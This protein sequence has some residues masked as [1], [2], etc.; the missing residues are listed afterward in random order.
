MQHS[1]LRSHGW[2]GTAALALASVPA[3][4]EPA[5]T[6]QGT[7]AELGVMGV[8]LKDSVKFNWGFQRA[9]Q[10]AGAHNQAGVGAFIPIHVGNN[11]VTYVDVLVNAN[12]S[13]YNGLSGIG[14]TKVSGSTATARGCKG[15]LRV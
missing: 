7:A 14:T 6:A 13:D 5:K 15:E 1:I 10:G 4:A 2:L 9:L 12:F 11:S 8:N 3:V